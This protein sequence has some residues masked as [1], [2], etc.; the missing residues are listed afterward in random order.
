MKSLN[1]VQLIGNLTKNPELKQTKS[2]T[3]VATFTV[4]TSRSIKNGDQWDEESEFHNVVIWG[5]QAEMVQQYV[6]KGQKLF[7]TGR[8]Q[9]RSYDKDGIKRYITEIVANDVV[10]MDSKKPQTQDV[11]LE[12]IDDGPIDLSGIPF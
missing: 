6:S 1:Q 5:K 3:S 10:F 2:G 7:V 8:L 12:D 11:V 4:A 9:T